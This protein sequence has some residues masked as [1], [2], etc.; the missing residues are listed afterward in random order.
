MHKPLPKQREFDFKRASLLS[1]LERVRAPA[2]VKSLLKAIDAVVREHEVWYATINTLAQSMGYGERNARRVIREAEAL[3]LI[4]VTRQAG[5]SHGYTIEWKAIFDLPDGAPED[6]ERRGRRPGRATPRTKADHP[7]Q[8]NPTP[9][10]LSAPPDKLSAPPDKL[11]GVCHTDHIN[12]HITAPTKAPKVEVVEI[13][14]LETRLLG[15]GVARARE[16]ID[17]ALSHKYPLG[18]VVAIVDHFQSCPGY[19]G[20][21]AL[22]RRLTLASGASI[23]ADQGWPPPNAK[24]IQ[25]QRRTHQ[26]ATQ[27]DQSAKEAQ[28]SEAN[29]QRQQERERRFGGIVDSL[30]EDQ[31]LRVLETGFGPGHFMINVFRRRGVGPS[32]RASL[33]DLLEKHPGIVA[34]LNEGALT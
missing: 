3:G 5:R 16:T 22:V 14:K 33:L 17:K 30:D 19:W 18:L 24:A 31:V 15:L 20:P 9:D 29:R 2:R 13:E 25:D 32:V 1:V 23:P 34:S 7:G 12:D 11:S 27:R 26:I 21:G 28:S 6:Q 10:K 4:K 8:I